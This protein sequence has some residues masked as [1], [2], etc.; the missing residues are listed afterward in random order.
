MIDS[1]QPV[2]H[3]VDRLHSGAVQGPWDGTW[4]QEA[5]R[6]LVPALAFVLIVNL[7]LVQPR[8]VHG[9]SMEPSLHES[10]RVI[11]DL[12]SY[13]VRPPKR[14]EIIVLAVP[15]RDAGPPLVKRV[16][17][18]PGDTVEIRYGSVYINGHKLDEPYLDQATDGAF[19][20]RL[21]PE[22]HVFVLGDNRRC[23]NDSRYFG[24]VP[25]D[26]ILGRAWLSYWPP[27]Q[28][29]LFD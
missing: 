29:G 15:D 8:V 27:S 24:T 25:Y 14:G 17:G 12:V 1:S 10:Q 4:L 20:S 6:T 2:R 22:E 23:S 28:V 3:D 18:V 5:L 7:L 13:R 11:L 26:H 16:I 19:S 9:E 21:I